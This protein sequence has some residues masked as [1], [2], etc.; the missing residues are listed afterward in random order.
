MFIVT[1]SSLSLGFGHSDNATTDKDK[2]ANEH[3]LQLVEQMA[4]SYADII[5]FE[6]KCDD[7][8]ATSEEISKQIECVED[9]NIL[10]V[11]LNNKLSTLGVAFA[12][13]KNEN[14]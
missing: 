8:F 13:M 14:P 3:Y 2:D 5:R 1:T 11:P 10:I 12:A 4:A 9:K 7:P 6:I